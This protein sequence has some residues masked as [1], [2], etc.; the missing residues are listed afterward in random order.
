MVPSSVSLP[1][2]K[3]RHGR[4]P[5]SC[6]GV[7][8]NR[9][10]THKVLPMEVASTP[11]DCDRTRRIVLRLWRCVLLFAVALVVPQAVSAQS[12]D[13][14]LW[15]TN[16]QVNAV[17][18]DGGKIY[19]GGDFTQVGPATGSAVPLDAATGL[20]LGMP[21]VAGLVNAV[22]P[23]GSG[24][25]YV[26]GS[27]MHVGGI[28]RSNLARILADHSVSTWDPGA[29]GPVQAKYVAEVLEG[30]AHAN[31]KYG[32]SLEVEAIQVTP[33]DCPTP[34]QAKYVSYLIARHAITGENWP[35]SPEP[36]QPE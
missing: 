30:V 31:I 10:R 19:I 3:L 23:D 24:G 7:G 35:S 5:V 12:I 13:Q 21:R 18:R 25:W 6:I 1:G 29:N 14:N 15:V 16:G 2:K 22:A 4:H 33:D 32:G 28:P 27:F 26:G 36:A 20:P 34:G 8:V 17:V 9:S 11:I